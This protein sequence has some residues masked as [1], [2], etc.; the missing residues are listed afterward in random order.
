MFVMGLGGGRPVQ[1]T[2]VWF[3]EQLASPPPDFK[4]TGTDI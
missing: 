2:S 3:A 1:F 4:N